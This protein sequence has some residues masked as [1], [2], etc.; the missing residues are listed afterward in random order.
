MV[1]YDFS[2]DY[3][4]G[5]PVKERG[6]DRN[7]NPAETYGDPML[8]DYMIFSPGDK[9]SWSWDVARDIRTEA[10]ADFFANSF[11]PDSEDECWLGS[12]RAT[13]KEAIVS[14]QQKM[15]ES[16]SWGD[17]FLAVKGEGQG[18]ATSILV[19]TLQTIRFLETNHKNDRKI[20][21]REWAQNPDTRRIILLS[22]FPLDKFRF[23]G[24]RKKISRTILSVIGH[25]SMTLSQ[26]FGGVTPE[27]KRLWFFLDEFPQ[28]GKLNL[29]P[30][31][32]EQG[33]AS[34]ICLILGVQDYTQ[35]KEIYG[36]KIAEQILANCG[37][38][39]ALRT[40]SPKTLKKLK[41]LFSATNGNTNT[42]GSHAEIVY[43]GKE[44][45]VFVQNKNLP[46]TL[47]GCG[48]VREGIR[49]VV[50]MPPTHTFLFT[51]PYVTWRTRRPASVGE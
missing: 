36:G 46:E 24:D 18:S 3:T 8:Q 15:G 25:V 51:W 13:I 21:F 30:K 49:A 48:P 47:S 50:S 23:F 9:R 19:N 33:R 26:P 38:R 43:P 39:I 4:A 34:G 22:E 42:I 7:A 5:F 6:V 27:K 37:I 16:W 31:L 2:G 1:I 17:L 20:S 45:P 11:V 14:L 10:D 12:V 28:L 32:F 35:L 40:L 29:L 44:T 41:K